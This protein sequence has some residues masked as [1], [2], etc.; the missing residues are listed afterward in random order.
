MSMYEMLFPD[1]A[2][3]H[4]MELL[5]H[6]VGFSIPTVARVRDAWPE[7]GET[8]PTVRVLARI[9]GGNRDDYAT[10]IDQL[11]ALPTYLV[12][13]DETRWDPTYASFWFR[14]V[15]QM[16][17]E[18]LDALQGRALAPVDL[19]ALAEAALEDAKARWGRGEFTP[20]EA[21]LGETLKAAFDG[22]GP[23]DGVIL[24]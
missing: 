11:R 5:S 1:E 12:D 18:L 23:P 22:D 9:G 2:R 3:P 15:D 20:A 21:A 10:A 19:A 7:K 24:I 16:P 8:G 17:A 6:I 13:K 14:P 4:R